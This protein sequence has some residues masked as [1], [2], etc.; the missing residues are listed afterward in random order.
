MHILLVLDGFPLKL[1]IF[2]LGCQLL[3]SGLMRKFPMIDPAAPLSIVA[4]GTN[5]NPHDVS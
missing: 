2:S 4:S 1:I 5:D 3:Y